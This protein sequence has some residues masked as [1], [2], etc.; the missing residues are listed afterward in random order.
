MACFWPGSCICQP[1]PNAIRGEGKG[2]VA[3][4][5]RLVDASAFYQGDHARRENLVDLLS[6]SLPH[7]DET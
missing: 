2:S 6:F 5:K 7:R 4:T 3:Q 1:L